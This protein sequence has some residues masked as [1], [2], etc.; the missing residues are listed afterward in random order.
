MFARLRRLF[1][2]FAANP[3]EYAVAT[4]ALGAIAALWMWPFLLG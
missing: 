4:A 1:A 2:A 3:D